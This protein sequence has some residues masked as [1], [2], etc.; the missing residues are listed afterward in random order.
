MPFASYQLQFSFP[1]WF[2]NAFISV[3]AYTGT[4]NDL[5]SS[6]LATVVSD[7]TSIISDV[8]TI[9]EQVNNLITIV[10]AIRLL[11]GG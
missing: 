5:P 2:K 10:N 6:E 9:A 7:V 1:V 11:V 4:T 3:W 8:A